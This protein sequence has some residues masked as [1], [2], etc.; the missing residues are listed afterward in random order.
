MVQQVSVML[1]NM[2]IELFGIVDRIFN[3]LDGWSFW[4]SAFIVYSASRFILLPFV[5]GQF[6]GV[7]SDIAR[8]FKSKEG[9]HSHTEK[10]GS[11]DRAKGE[12]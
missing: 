1:G 12:K 10:S 9:F 7:G 4:L 2:F 8:A 6:A 3:A 5:R 11:S